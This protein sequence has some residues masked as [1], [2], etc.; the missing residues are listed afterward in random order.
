MP[1]HKRGTVY[2]G[3]LIASRKIDSGKFTTIFPAPVKPD[4]SK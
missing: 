1:L 2:S 3:A 4:R